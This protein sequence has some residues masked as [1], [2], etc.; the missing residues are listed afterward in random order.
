MPAWS[1]STRTERYAGAKPSLTNLPDTTGSSPAEPR[2]RNFMHLPRIWLQR[3]YK[4]ATPASALLV[5][6]AVSLL[7]LYGDRSFYFTL[8]E[9]WCVAPFRFPFVDISGSLAAWECARQGADV[10]ISD[11]CDV[12]QRPY[13]YSPIWMSWSAIPLGVSDTPAVGWFSGLVFLLSLG[14]LPHPRRPLEL[15]LTLLATLSGAVVFAV[16]RA[17]PDILLF[18]LALVTALSAEGGLGVRLIG[19]AA[20]VLSG[21]VKYYPFVTLVMVVEERIPVYLSVSGAVVLVLATFGVVYHDEIVRGLPYIPTGTYIEGVFGAKNLP[22]QF[23]DMTTAAL[24]PTS[25]LG[26]VVAAACAASLV[27]GVIAIGRCFTID[28]RLPA[29]MSALSFRE[30]NLLVVGSA[31]I[32]GCFFTGQNVWYRAIFLLLVMPGL[33]AIG[34]E[35]TSRRGYRWSL[36][37]SIA[38][39]FLMWEEC[40][41]FDIERITAAVD[42]STPYAAQLRFFFWLTREAVWWWVVAILTAI[43]VEFL[44]RSAVVDEAVS[45]LRRSGGRARVLVTGK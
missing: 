42:L 21:L 32:C 20:A 22:L 16:E 3:F 10:I 13:S 18:M 45:W 40:V 28:G 36:G 14:M 11:P 24:G 44:R 39:V 31:V 23:G 19:Y 5:F 37:T 25:A 33:F 15:I 34:R 9:N 7:Y 12:L 6:F 4:Y 35:A 2:L 8:L 38:I 1:A 29:A 17:N 27:L 41:R 43:L 26:T 30:R